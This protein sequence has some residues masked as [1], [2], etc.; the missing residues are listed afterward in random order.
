MRLLFITATYIG[1]SVLSSGVLQHVM[2]RHPE[3]R[4]T[5]AAS[6]IAAPLFEAIPRLERIHIIVKTRYAGHWFELWRRHAARRWEVVA[7]LRGSAIGYCFLAGRRVML[8]RRDRSRHTVEELSALFGIEPPPALTVWLAPRHEAQAETL[9]PAGAPVL[10][11]GPG[12]NWAGKQW[13]GERFA[14]VIGH[15]TGPGGPLEGARVAVLAAGHERAQ[16]EPVL[17]ALPD[18]RRIDL[19]GKVDLPTAAACLRRSALFIGNDSGL[20]HLAAAAGTPTL[21]LFGPSPEWR[22]RPW[23]PRADYVRTRESFDELF[24][25]LNGGQRTPETLMDGLEVETV[26]GAAEGLLARVGGGA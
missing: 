7:D 6:P 4:V 3:A 24:A 23:S 9:I 14:A 16:A 11:V 21:G 18:A 26:I 10:A 8:G 19:V 25:E 5:V 12:A 1:D 17:A 22:Y 15:V 2:D 13:P 20:M